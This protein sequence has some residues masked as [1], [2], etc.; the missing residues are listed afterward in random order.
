[1]LI[2]CLN[3]VERATGKN[4]RK[5]IYQELYQK[6]ASDVPYIFLYFPETILG[7]NKRVKGLSEAGPAG[8]MN[9]IENVYLVQ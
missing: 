3:R 7:V 1:M 6:I 9:P 2:S 4:D 5:V 8:L